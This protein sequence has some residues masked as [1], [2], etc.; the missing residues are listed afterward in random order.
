MNSE[1]NSD[2]IK[3]RMEVGVGHSICGRGLHLY[4]NEGFASVWLQLQEC[5]TELLETHIY[6]CAPALTV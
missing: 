5:S 6:I 4:F 1:A 3:G 2:L